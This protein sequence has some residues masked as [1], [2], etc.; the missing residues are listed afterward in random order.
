MILFITVAHN[1]ERKGST[2]ANL[3]DDIPEFLNATDEIDRVYGDERFIPI[4]NWG[5]D[6]GKLVSFFLYLIYFQVIKYQKSFLNCLV[7]FFFIKL[8]RV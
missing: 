2:T 5:G 1:I 6:I 3:E 7:T 4:G 8:I